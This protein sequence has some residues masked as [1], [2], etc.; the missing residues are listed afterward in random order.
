MVAWGPIIGAGISAIGSLFG[1]SDDEE[2]TTRV[3]YK[4]MA[5]D[6]MEAGFNPLTAIRNGGSAGFTTTTHP[7][8]SSA[9]FGAAFQTLGNA[10]MS[11]DAR[12]DERAGL[13]NQI[14]EA[15]LQ[16][17]NRTNAAASMNFFGDVPQAAGSTRVGPGNRPLAPI[18]PKA[19]L[20]SRAN[21]APLYRF[22]VDPD[23]PNK[24]I[25]KIPNID[26]VP[27]D[28]SGLLVG[29]LAEGGQ[30]LEDAVDFF[31]PRPN[32]KPQGNPP[33]PRLP[34][35][36]TSTGPSLGGAI[37]ALKDYTSPWKGEWFYP[38]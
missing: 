32:N 22:V 30:D 5:N 21:P 9:G 2:T 34:G 14:L 28:P 24:R 12:A 36:P 31:R 15:Q 10:L 19:E 13:E 35:L 26:F 27:D 29:G 11:F 23:D 16:G 25:I 1:G 17:L 33:G 20:G 3:D 38:W 4:R 7:A 18:G 6:A 37:D 8:L